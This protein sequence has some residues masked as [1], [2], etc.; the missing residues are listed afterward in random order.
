MNGSTVTYKADGTE[1]TSCCG[2]WTTYSIADGD[3]VLCCRACYHEIVGES[4]EDTPAIPLAPGE[5]ACVTIQ[6]EERGDV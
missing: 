6:L 4:V 5:S 1:S 3:A 2:A